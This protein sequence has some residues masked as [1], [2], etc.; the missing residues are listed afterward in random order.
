MLREKEK[1][2][3]AAQMSPLSLRKATPVPMSSMDLKAGQTVRISAPI[4]ETDASDIEAGEVGVIEEI[5]GEGIWMNIPK[6]ESLR[7]VRDRSIIDG[8]DIH[9]D[10][11]GFNTEVMITRDSHHVGWRPCYTTTLYE[12]AV[13]SYMQKHTDGSVDVIDSNGITLTNVPPLYIRHMEYRISP[14][15]VY[16]SEVAVMRKGDLVGWATC[17]IDNDRNDGTYDITTLENKEKI[18]R[19]HRTQLRK[20]LGRGVKPKEHRDPEHLVV[21]SKLVTAALDKLDPDPEDED[22][23]MRYQSS[24]YLDVP[25]TEGLAQLADQS[26]SFLKTLTP[27]TLHSEEPDPKYENSPKEKRL[28]IPLTPSFL[29]TEL[30]RDTFLKITK[31][32][33]YTGKK[34]TINLAGLYLQE[35]LTN[36]KECTGGSV[37]IKCVEDEGPDCFMLK[38]IR[39]S[40]KLIV[41]KFIPPERQKPENIGFLRLAS[42]NSPSVFEAHPPGPISNPL[43]FN[44]SL[45]QSAHTVRISTLTVGVGKKKYLIKLKD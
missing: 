3:K 4:Y 26:E 21:L 29:L 14:R 1:R 44:P 16:D 42:V 6:H 12:R 20:L 35:D 13:T 37:S 24:I 2:K 8:M 17:R 7:L 11:R 15:G 31:K 28:R 34:F 30:N 40:A 38:K 45:S 43:Y 10:P 19:V 36:R 23:V 18:F 9:R 25:A 33:M 5:D 32:A 22:S 41:D 27:P 39:H